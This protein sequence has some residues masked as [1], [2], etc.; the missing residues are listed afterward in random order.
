MY[1]Q[2]WICLGQQGELQVCI[3][4]YVHLI[5][6]SIGTKPQ[7]SACTSPQKDA[8]ISNK[9]QKNAVHKKALNKEQEIIVTFSRI[10]IKIV[11]P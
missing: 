1:E 8:C 11:T 7:K 9:P 10:I 5:A 3:P 4:L 6:L 2:T